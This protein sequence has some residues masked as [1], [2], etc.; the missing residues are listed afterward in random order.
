M[1]SI[2]IMVVWTEYFESLDLL[3][4]VCDFVWLVNI[5][6]RSLTV[7]YDIATRDPCEI[8]WF[9]VKGDLAVDI[10][11]TIPSIVT[12]H[13]THVHWTRVF[14]VVYY[15]RIM[16]EPA[17]SL[18]ISNSN[19][20]QHKRTIVRFLIKFTSWLLIISHYCASIWLWLGDKYLTED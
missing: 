3:V 17:E 15:S 8:F 18:F 12:N 11:S 10:L 13:A 6:I 5:F 14:H 20:T 16:L 4:W 19:L 9:Y 2:P 1:L 7:R